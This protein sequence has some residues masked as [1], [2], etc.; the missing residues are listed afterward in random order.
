MESAGPSFFDTAEM[1][2]LCEILHINTFYPVLA[3]LPILHTFIFSAVNFY[4]QWPWMDCSVPLW[5]WQTA[6]SAT[7]VHPALRV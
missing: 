4:E 6:P 5:L 2:P 1:N 3:S 7:L